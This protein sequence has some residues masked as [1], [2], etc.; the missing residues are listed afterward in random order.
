MKKSIQNKNRALN[1]QISNQ[2]KEEGK[3]NEENIHKT[4][5]AKGIKKQAEKK[6]TKR[7]NLDEDNLLYGQ[8]GIR[9][10]YDII[11]QTDFKSSKEV[12]RIFIFFN[13]LRFWLLLKL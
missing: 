10:F 5:K 6:A 1:D 9:K 3:T 2:D 12:K 4:E 13:N 8:N 11:M 7:V